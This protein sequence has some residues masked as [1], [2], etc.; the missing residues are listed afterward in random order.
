METGQVRCF[1]TS[2]RNRRTLANFPQPIK[3]SEVMHDL[4]P[5]PV[6]MARV[7]LNIAPQ[8]QLGE[9]SHE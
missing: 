1:L 4:P 3:L 2:R 6:W 8:H 7:L 5:R 9:T